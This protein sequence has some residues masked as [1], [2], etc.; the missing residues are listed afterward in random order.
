[1]GNFLEM[2]YEVMFHPR[3]AMRIIAA[4]KPVGQAMA[5]FV[6][7]MAVSAVVLYSVLQ[8]AGSGNMTALVIGF[9]FFFSLLS[10]VFGAAVFN[11]LAEYFGGQSNGMGLFAALGFTYLPRLFIAPLWALAAF[12]SVGARP[13]VLMAGGIA[14]AGWT[15]VLMVHA[16]R[17][18]HGLS[19]AQAVL[20]LLTPLLVLGVLSLGMMLFGVAALPWRLS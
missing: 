20:T 15:I 2:L 18:A 7:G 9:H 10:W 1:M 3:A 5:V 19:T 14:I 6:T 16:L 4:W 13:W 17:G 8:S 11:L 12:F